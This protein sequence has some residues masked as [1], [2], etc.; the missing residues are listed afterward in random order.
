MTSKKQRHVVAKEDEFKVGART[1]L[2]VGGVSSGIE[3]GQGPG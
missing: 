1:I 2:K 3:V